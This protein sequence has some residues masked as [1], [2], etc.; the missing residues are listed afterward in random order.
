MGNDMAVFRIQCGQGQGRFLDDHENEGKLKFA[1]V[2]SV[3]VW[4]VED[5]TETWEKE[6][7]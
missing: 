5:E 3:G 2:Q 1:G 7:T 4:H 6:G